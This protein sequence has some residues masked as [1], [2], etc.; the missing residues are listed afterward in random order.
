MTTCSTSACGVG[1]WGGPLPGDPDNNSV[2]TAS[3]AFGGVDVSWSYPTTNPAAVAHV[4]LYRGLSSNFNSAILIAT[5]GGNFFYDKST[6]TQLL[7]QFYWIQIVSVNGTVGTLIG[8]ASAVAKPPIASVIEGLTAQ[9][10]AGFLA[11]SLKTEIDRITLNSQDILLEI[12]N[13][14]ATEN[15]FTLGLAQLQ[16][17]VDTATT[18]L[19]EEI[20]R[21]QDGDS[22]LVTQV[23]LI[24]AANATNQAAIQTETSA[25]V[26][27]DSAIS[28]SVTQ[29]S[30]QTNDPTTGLP[31]TRS[32]LLTNYYTKT[33]ANSAISSATTALGS[34]FDSKLTGYTNTAT[35]TQNYYTKADTNSAIASAT[36]TLVSNTSLNT[37]LGSYQT[38]AALQLD[39]YTKTDT[40]SAIASATTSLVST[41]ALNTALSG[42]TNT[43]ALQNSYYTKTQT[44]SA[45]STATQTLVSTTALNTALGSYTNTASLQTNYYTKT[46]TDSAIS[47]AV[48]TSQTT[49]NANIASSQTTLQTNI[50]TVD[51]KVTSIGALYT[52]KVSVNGLI[53][54]FGIY[55][56]GTTVDAG[57]DVSTFW[58][59]T[60]QANKR[61]P[62]II[63]NG[64]TYIDDAVIEKLTFSKLRDATGSFIVENGKVKADY[65]NVT[66]I[67]GGTFTGYAWPAAGQKGFYLGPSG[68]LLGNYNGGGA[69][70]QYDV[71]TGYL[72]V[73]GN[74]RFSGLL[75]N[76]ITVTS[77]QVIGSLLK[78]LPIPLFYANIAYYIDFGTGSDNGNGPYYF[79]GDAGPFYP[80]W[81]GTMPA[82]ETA[83]HRIAG[84]VSVKAENLAGGN[85][86]DMVVRLVVNYSRS[87]TTLS[88]EVIGEVVTSGSYNMTAAVAAASSGTYGTA[89]TLAI[90]VSGYNSYNRVDT[91]SGLFWGVR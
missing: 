73:G 75:A 1:G 87:G 80:V 57:F 41:T 40:N 19:S 79:P 6:S 64:V 46:A 13:R 31:A 21:R 24:A 17:N 65:L 9:I 90:L 89:V 38:K 23:N 11:Q 91:V 32:L 47:S 25:R 5:V 77:G 48:T 66:T 82:P 68:L 16:L 54:G 51:G 39:Y 20:T 42:Y 35:L 18:Y 61:K 53:G 27:A 84:V 60:T 69:Y 52:A 36:S 76:T 86:K 56:N 28:S 15:V 22:A 12:Q 49:L 30:S 85:A 14:I 8:P 50:N 71:A 4:L 26:T 70:L 55:N 7:T 43:A 88:G 72:E 81:T 33:D 83:A 34:Q 29:L 58:V 78:I 62:F 3:P 45:I 10:D 59:G 37:T 63:S 74:A 67:T 2:L 44:D